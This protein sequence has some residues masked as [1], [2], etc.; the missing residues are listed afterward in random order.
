MSGD[1]GDMA[2]KGDFSLHDVV[3][4]VLIMKVAVIILFNVVI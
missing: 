1:D 3:E 4:Y 2:V